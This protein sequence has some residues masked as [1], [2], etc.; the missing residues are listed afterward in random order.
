MEAE[1][2]GIMDFFMEWC[3]LNHLQL[4]SS[5][6]KE[7]VVNFSRRRTLP[8]LNSIQGM[9]VKIR[10]GP[11]PTLL[12]DKTLIIQCLQYPTEDVL[13]VCGGGPC[14]VEDIL[15]G[16]VRSSGRLALSRG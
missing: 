9:D 16:S 13:L 5:K 10:P 1:C 8:T 7:L 3:M 4:N 11:E 6:T 15:P 14:A 12:S 2:R